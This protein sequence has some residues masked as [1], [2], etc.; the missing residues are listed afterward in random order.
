[1]N[2]IDGSNPSPG[3][4]VFYMGM[5]NMKPNI[6]V[7]KTTLVERHSIAKALTECQVKASLSEREDLASKIQFETTKYL[8]GRSNLFPLTDPDSLFLG[9]SLSDLGF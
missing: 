3:A 2:E 5:L 8:G 9:V 6:K 7:D 4:K 1:M